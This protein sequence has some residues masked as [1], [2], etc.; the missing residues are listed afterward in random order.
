M[1]TSSQALRS[2]IAVVIAWSGSTSSG[3]KRIDLSSDPPSVEELA[4]HLTVDLTTTGRRSG[5]PRRIEI[6]WFH[7][8]ERFYIT[9]TPGPRDWYANILADPKVMVHAGGRDLEGLAYPVLDPAT[10]A[11]V[12]D[13]PK[14]RWYSTQ[15]ERQRLIDEAPMVEIVLDS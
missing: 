11:D 4:R 6:W 14:T 12:F 13:H 9:G 7:V 5:R 8:G 3:K 2:P 15:A 1:E 10:R